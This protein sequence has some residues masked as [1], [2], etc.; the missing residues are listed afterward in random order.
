M[1]EV[2]TIVD[3][4][5]LKK[6]GL[7]KSAVARRLGISRDTVSK[8]WNCVQ[9]EP[10]SYG[11]RL[12]LIDPYEN[13]ITHRLEEYPELSAQQLYDDIRTKG[14]KGSKRTV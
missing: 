14:Y 4:M 6:Q 5:R 7:S 3:I 1:T 8:Y 2:A 13:Y 9:L 10:D 11:P 12:K